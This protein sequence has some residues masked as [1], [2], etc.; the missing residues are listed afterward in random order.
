MP[1]I[2][3]AIEALLSYQQADMEGVMVLTSRQAIHEVADEL[4]RVRSHA[5]CDAAYSIAMDALVSVG[6]QDAFLDMPRYTRELV[7]RAIEKLAGVAEQS[8]AGAPET[9]VRCGAPAATAQGARRCE[10]KRT[11]ARLEYVKCDDCGAIRAD[12]RWGIASCKWFKSLDEARFYR[13]NGRLPDE[14]AP[15]TPAAVMPAQCGAASE[16]KTSP[17]ELLYIASQQAW[18][19][20]RYN[21]DDADLIRESLVIEWALRRAAGAPC[22]CG[23]GADQ[24]ASE[25]DI[26]CHVAINPST[27]AAPFHFRRYVNGV[28]MAEDVEI[29]N[30]ATVQ[31]A[32]AEARRLYGRPKGMDLVL[33]QSAPLTPAEV[34][35]PDDFAQFLRDVEREQGNCSDE[36]TWLGYRQTAEAI[37][38]KFDVRPKHSSTN[39]SSAPA[40]PTGDTRSGERPPASAA[41]G[42]S[43]GAE[44][45]TP[46]ER[47]DG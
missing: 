42:H 45:Y 10:H 31:E 18:A 32:F 34:V 26:S 30:A 33:E 37:L 5:Q 1:N 28:E 40:A 9:S 46:T 44:H 12:A 2:D 8:G 36:D 27:L 7:D 14:I 41:M 43:A 6:N 23:G 22:T 29:S 24:P 13:D 15:R 20:G 21:P 11:T 35:H 39:R 38:E 16:V 4:K 47:Q 25:H 19:R 3:E 17:E